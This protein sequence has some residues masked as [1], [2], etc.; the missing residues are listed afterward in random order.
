MTGYFLSRKT[1]L[2]FTDLSH[3]YQG[4]EQHIKSTSFQG[5]DDWN[6]PQVSRQVRQ[7]GWRVWSHGIEGPSTSLCLIH[8]HTRWFQF[9]S[10]SL[11]S[12]FRSGF[13]AMKTVLVKVISDLHV[14]RH[15]SQLSVLTSLNLPES[16][17]RL[18]SPAP[19]GLHLTPRTQLLSQFFSCLTGFFPLLVLLLEL[20]TLG[21]PMVYFVG[22]FLFL[23]T[24]LFLVISSILMAFS[25]VYLQTNSNFI[26][27]A[28]FRVQLPTQH[29][30]QMF[31]RHLRFNILKLNFSPFPPIY[32][33]HS[34]SI[35]VH[36]NPI[37][38]AFQTNNPSIILQ[39]S[40]SGT[41]IQCVSKSIDYTFTV[42]ISRIWSLVNTNTAPTLSKLLNSLCLFP[43]Q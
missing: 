5:T 23:S 34:L 42:N 31:N 6:A 41:H 26:S 36:D 18:I 28:R 2:P 9:L 12:P 24:F 29:L 4:Q 25:A 11:L 22:L 1:P 40:F 27:A 10:Y 15:N 13:H 19:W 14:A 43:Y 37:L 21:C 20:L 7:H 3:P 17:P 16:L 38:V 30:I 8:T 35:S 39:S 33:S 32:P